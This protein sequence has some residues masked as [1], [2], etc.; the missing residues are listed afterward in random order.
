MTGHAPVRA[1]PALS[2]VP[3][4]VHFPAITRDVLASGLRVWSVHRPALPVV[5]VALVVDTGSAYDPPDQPGLASLSAD[6]LDEGA[7]GRDAV[8][9]SDA[10]ARLGAHLDVEAGQELTSLSLTTLSKNL[11]AVLA[12]LSDVVLRPHLAE[13]DVTRIRELRLN[14]LRQMKVSA[15]T[16]ADR[17]FLGGVFGPH[18]YGHGTL[19]TTRAL[20]AATLDDVRD[21]KSTRLNSS[22][23]SESRMPSS[24]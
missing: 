16:A 18:P 6:L 1:R 15:A 14:R 5:T 12:L 24:A 13:A 8:Q 2:G 21:R 7:G 9:L 22:H 10:F 3:T 20:Q 17:A 19:G 11:D 4:S 23:V